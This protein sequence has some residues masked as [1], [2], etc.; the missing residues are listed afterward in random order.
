MR[1]PAILLKCMAKLAL[2]SVTSGVRC[3]YLDE[4]VELWEGYSAQTTERSRAE[5]AKNLA[6]CNPAQFAMLVKEVVEDIDVESNPAAA[7]EIVSM[8]GEAKNG[9]A[10]RSNLALNSIQ[11]VQSLLPEIRRVA[12][13]ADPRPRFP[14][15]LRI[16]VY[17]AI[18]YSTSQGVFL[19]FPFEG[20]AFAMAAGSLQR[21]MMYDLYAMI[22]H[23]FGVTDGTHGLGIGA[24]IEDPDDRPYKIEV[25]QD[26]WRDFMRAQ[27]K[28][29]TIHEVIRRINVRYDLP[30]S[31]YGMSVGQE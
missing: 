14:N 10:R 20:D 4:A 24:L 21:D 12:F 22:K 13:E 25:T 23:C 3:D 17:G 9:L 7:H 18:K 30:S 1:G 6:K 15:G 31:P 26:V 16:G 2:N 19:L 8:L 11:D 27:H 29:M 5:D 28:G